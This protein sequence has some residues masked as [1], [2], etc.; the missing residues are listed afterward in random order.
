MSSDRLQAPDEQSASAPRHSVLQQMPF[1]QNPL[2]HSRPSLQ[3]L[4]L[5]LR[6]PHAPSPSQTLRPHSLSGS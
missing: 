3:R 6:S 5:I 2:L 4:P 1:E